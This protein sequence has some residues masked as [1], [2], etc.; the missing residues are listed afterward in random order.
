MRKIIFIVP[1]LVS[2][3]TL[4]DTILGFYAGVSNWQH[5]MAGN[6]NSD[7]SVSDRVDI[8]FD[9]GGNIFYAAL[10]HPVPFL[11]N[12]KVQQ[13]DVQAN[14]LINISDVAAFPG[15]SVD[16]NGDIDFSHTDI[17]L[18]YEILDN[19]LNLDL[20]LSFKYFNGYSD[21]YYQD[22]LDDKSDFDDWI[23]M[24]YAKGQ[25]DLPLTGFSVY[26]SVEAL[27]F[28]SNDVTDFEVGLNYESKV[29]LGGVVGYRAL[30]VD[31]IN[32]GDLTSDLKIDG[33]FAGINFHF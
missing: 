6:I 12:I 20:G 30:S 24:L 15:Q 28:D 4:A 11:P 32:I 22:M 14:G 17:M 13:N 25:V 33:F 26:G 21:F 23:P 1:M 19:A 16:V 10:E 2:Q 31:L 29:G 18:Y 9:N 3:I 27:S 5:D 7:L 8:N